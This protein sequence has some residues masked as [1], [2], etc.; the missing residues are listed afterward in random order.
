MILADRRHPASLIPF[1]LHNPRLVYLM[2]KRVNMDMVNYVARRTE[3]VFSIDPNLKPKDVI[4]QL[5]SLDDFIVHLVK[6]SNVQVS[7]LLT[8]LV[9]L[10]RIRSRVS[11]LIKGMR[12]TPHRLFLATLIVTAKYLNDASPK[13]KHWAGYAMV[14][15][16]DEINVMEKQ[17]LSLL[18]YDL[19]F[20]EAEVCAIFAPFMSSEQDANT[21]ASAVDKVTR[22]SRARVQAWQDTEAQVPPPPPTTPSSQSLTASLN[23]RGIVKRASSTLSMTGNDYNSGMRSTLSNTSTSTSS[24]DMASLLDDTGSS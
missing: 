22:A 7:T 24:S 11:P 8:T 3:K 5:I 15:S 14:F 21:R 1:S 17:L 16:V 10:E 4:V 6:G 9:Y 2:S 19:R 13:N 12:G 20:D 18:N 23:V